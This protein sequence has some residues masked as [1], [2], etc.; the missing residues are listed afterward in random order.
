MLCYNSVLFAIQ[1]LCAARKK[2]IES[3]Q[4]LKRIQ[5]L[6]RAR[7]KRETLRV[8]QAMDE[9]KERKNTHEVK[10]LFFADTAEI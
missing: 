7:L 5:L 2:E 6:E 10:Y 3:E 1:A 4:H 9:L 8:E